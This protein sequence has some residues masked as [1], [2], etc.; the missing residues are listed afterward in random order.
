MI[1]PGVGC[2][3]W[4]TQ[5]RSFGFQRR[6]RM[7][8]ERTTMRQV[9]EVLRLKFVGGVPIREIARRIG[10]AASTVRVTLKRFQTTSLSWPLPEE[11]TDVA[12][13]ARLFPD[14]GTK[15]GRR[16]QVEPDWGSIHREL[17]RKHV[18]LSILWDEYIERHPQGYRYSRFCECS[19]ILSWSTGHTPNRDSDPALAS[20]GW[21]GRS[22]SYGW[23]P[24]PRAP[25][26]SARSPTDRSVPSSTTNSIDP[27]RTSVPRTARRSSI[28]T[29]AARA[30][31]NRRPNLA[32]PSH[33]RSAASAR[34]QRHGQGL[35]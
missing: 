27:P 9:R 2:L 12:L 26:R 25:L 17:K 34:S 28:P 24:P 21:R 13:E 11:L 23:K 16:R 4:P 19:A 35:R 8:A 3:C 5:V 6:D 15:Q 14:A 31:I 20:C 33:P 7:P 32:H 1:S 18:T 10:V 30:T 29:S 22:V